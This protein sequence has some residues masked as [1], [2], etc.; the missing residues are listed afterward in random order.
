MIISV[1]MPVYNGRKF[2]SEAVKSIR[3]QVLPAG[4]QLEL[5]VVDD[6][7]DDG[8]AAEALR[9]DESIVV[10]RADRVGNVKARNIA[11]ARARGQFIAFCD[12]DDVWEPGKLQAQMEAFDARSTEFAASCC[13]VRQID[14]KGAS[15]RFKGLR[16]SE[17]DIRRLLVND[18]VMPVPLSGWVVRREVMTQWFTEDLPVAA[19]LELAVRI[20]G[21]HRI[22]YVAHPLLKYRLHGGSITAGRIDEQQAVRRYLRAS[23]GGDSVTYSAWKRSYRATMRD[24]RENISARHFRQ[25]GNELAAKR[26][27]RAAWSFLIASILDPKETI[28]KFAAQRA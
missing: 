17:S 2:I 6:G 23:R 14:S 8:S 4:Y 27:L 28:R 24:K 20:A 26:Y 22:H 21:D 15:I 3:S 16:W 7:S 11:I 10:I 13:A 12:A 25:T 5:V 19:D 1:V 18:F 9:A